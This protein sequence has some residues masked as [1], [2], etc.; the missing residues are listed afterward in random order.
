MSKVIEFRPKG[1]NT[2]ANK[3]SE[4]EAIYTMSLMLNKMA[5]SLNKIALGRADQ[6][7]YMHCMRSFMFLNYLTNQSEVMAEI[8]KIAEQRKAK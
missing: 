5:D 3:K 8:M 2:E 7:D 6:D 1:N 4:N